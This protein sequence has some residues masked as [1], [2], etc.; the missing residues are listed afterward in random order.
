MRVPPVQRGVRALIAGL[1]LCSVTVAQTQAQTDRIIADVNW[2]GQAKGRELIVLR[3]GDVLVEQKTLQRFGVQ[4]ATSQCENDFGDEFVDLSQLR[5][6]LSYSF[7]VQSLTLK[8][9][10]NPSAL[11]HQTIAV[12]NSEPTQQSEVA[13][14]L[15]L[16]YALHGSP[17]SALSGSLTQRATL[18]TNQAVENTFGRTAAGVIT[19]GRSALTIDAPNDMRR[20]VV[21][22]SIVS[23]GLLGSSIAIGGLSV[24]R[25]F[26]LDP[27]QP[28]FPMP[29]MQ[30]TVTSPSF[31]DIYVNGMLVKTLSLA[32]GNYN[33]SDIPIQAGYTNAQIVLRNEFGARTTDIVEYGAPA[34]LR[35]GLSDYQYGVGFQRTDNAGKVTYGS[36]A[37]SARYRIGVSPYSTVG[38]ALQALPGQFNGDFS[39]AG[40]W[41]F[42]YVQAEGAASDVNSLKGSAFALRYTTSGRAAAASF[43]ARFQSPSYRSIG[44]AA[45]YETLS[46]DYTITATKRLNAQ[47]DASVSARYAN[48]RE[49]G[50]VRD[51]TLSLAHRFQDWNAVAGFIVGSTAGTVV[52]RTN[53]F[54]VTL[55]RSLGRSSSLTTTAGG[56]RQDFSTTIAHSADSPLS[57]SYSASFYPG[58]QNVA[59]VTS[60]F[61][62]PFASANISV[63]AAEASTVGMNADI[64]GSIVLAQGRAFFSQTI[65]DAYALVRADETPNAEVYLNG[66]YVARTNRAGYAIVPFVASNQQ[67][68]I[69]LS[70]D[71]LALDEIL[72]E[73]DRRI[74]PAFHAGTDV[75][76]AVHRVHAIFGT[77]RLRHNGK[78]R[79]P[80][81]G[82]ID[83]RLSGASTSSSPIDESGR[84]YLDG[85]T[86]GSLAATV[87][88]ESGSCETQLRIPSFT[89]GA[90]DLGTIECA[91]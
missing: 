10:S 25:D 17:G 14:G 33:L 29:A 77:L 36:P 79:V 38:A 44:Q 13:K 37:A 57:T 5:N 42:G 63:N 67:N 73:N 87:A 41:R 59:A 24:A 7:D 22:D 88:D 4:V 68:H 6:R 56:T 32:P 80:A 40:V 15:V 30:T 70:S 45:D 76:F 65:D 26:S 89:E 83:V 35:K 47:T 1:F 11:P 18:R 66:R 39:Y 12:V 85:I 61:G 86:A 27:Y 91:Y 60:H 64:A 53:D 51:V 52:R 48:Y 8:V 75:R 62:L 71:G 9:V 3:D 23:G 21:G 82:Q 58:Q 50:T 49:S 72:G 74:S 43:Q 69:A 16:S 19:R 84:F 55:M 34:L 54:T 46:N 78:V 31:A 81:F 28:T 90:R 20:T 2:D